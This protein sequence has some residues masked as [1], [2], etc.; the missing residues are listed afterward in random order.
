MYSVLALDLDLSL[1]FPGDDDAIVLVP[2]LGDI[3]IRSDD[4]PS[5]HAQPKQG[6]F[7]GPGGEIKVHIAT[8]TALT[9]I[10][11]SK[12][13]LANAGARI[14]SRYL[15]F[16]QDDACIRTLEGMAAANVSVHSQSQNADTLARVAYYLTMTAARIALQRDLMIDLDPINHFGV[17]MSVISSRK[18]DPHLSVASL[19]ESLS[20]SVRQ[21]NRVFQKEGTTVA[22]EIRRARMLEARRLL[23]NS[24]ASQ[25]LSLDRIA[26]LSGFPSVAALR[27][28][29]KAEGSPE[30]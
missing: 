7:I 11:L 21:L 9:I 19:A 2:A 24:P 20:L 14:P 26:S 17:A 13:R 29:A 5:I 8:S 30:N 3:V 22:R 27:R 23:E 16:V 10:V 28:A 1:Q 4:E 15:R 18:T 25:R 12:K 6:V